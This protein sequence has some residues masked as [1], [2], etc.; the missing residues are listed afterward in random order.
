[1]SPLVS[2]EHGEVCTCAITDLVLTSPDS[3]GVTPNVVR[4]EGLSVWNSSAFDADACD[5]GDPL[6]LLRP[7]I[8]QA[9][10]NGH[11]TAQ[12]SVGSR[13]GLKGLKGC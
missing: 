9:C 3:R 10:R 13:S 8:M 2:Q 7:V 1:M 6:E 5:W 4:C 12:V 11:F